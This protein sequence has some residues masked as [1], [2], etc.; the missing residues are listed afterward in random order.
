MN[1]LEHELRYP[2]SEVPAAGTVTT[3]RPGVHWLRMPL[4]F[5]L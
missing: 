5:A 1:P 4:P 2:W 3:L